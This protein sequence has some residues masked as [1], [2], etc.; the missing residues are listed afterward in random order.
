MTLTVLLFLSLSRTVAQE[1][2]SQVQGIDSAVNSSEYIRQEVMSL[3]RQTDTMIANINNI[4][5]TVNEVLL[6]FIK[7][8][9]QVSGKNEKPALFADSPIDTSRF[10]RSS[11]AVEN[12][13][14]ERSWLQSN[15]SLKRRLACFLSCVRNSG[16][17]V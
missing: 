4:T 10:A 14:E 16:G 9:V 3:Q 2:L 1:T 6:F 11:P 5:Q 7:T 15:I 12:T 8:V 13:G 17:C